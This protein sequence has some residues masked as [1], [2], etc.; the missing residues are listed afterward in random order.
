MKRKSDG[1]LA[2]DESEIESSGEESENDRSQKRSKVKEAHEHRQLTLGKKKAPSKISINI[3]NISN[4]TEAIEKDGSDV[5]R[6][7]EE[8]QEKALDQPISETKEE[9]KPITK[10]GDDYVSIEELNSKKASPEGTVFVA[11]YQFSCTMLI[12]LDT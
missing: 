7:T 1:L 11:A 8:E 10:E 12:L 5:N 9:T 2:S 6:P 4:A 3:S